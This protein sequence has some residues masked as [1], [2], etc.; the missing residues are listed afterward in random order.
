MTATLPNPSLEPNFTSATPGPVASL[1]MSTKNLHTI[2]S[3]ESIVSPASTQPATTLSNEQNPSTVVSSA[4]GL[5][6]PAYQSVEE[7]KDAET[8][9]L[10]PAN[11][12]VIPPSDVVPVSMGE[13]NSAAP[14][15]D[16]LT[17]ANLEPEISAL[18]DDQTAKSPLP[19]NLPLPTNLGLPAMHVMAGSMPAAP[20]NPSFTVDSDSALVASRK[21]TIMRPNPQST[22]AR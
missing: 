12:N 5:T 3:H 9:T 4:G 7:G 8:T 10:G 22:T 11:S 14:P 18:S 15:M 19:M 17:R 16:P 6:N 13:A 21:G 1:Q 2:L 20:A